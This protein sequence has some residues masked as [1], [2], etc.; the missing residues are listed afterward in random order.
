METMLLQ[1]TTRSSPDGLIFLL[2]HFSS[3]KETV[4]A[5]LQ[6]IWRFCYTYDGEPDLQE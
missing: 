5:D 1:L 4:L 6:A 3:I 2:G